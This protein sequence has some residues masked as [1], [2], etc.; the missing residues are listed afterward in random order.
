MPPS[1]VTAL[2]PITGN[3]ARYSIIKQRP[4]TLI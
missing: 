3:E 2:S 4:H 1:L